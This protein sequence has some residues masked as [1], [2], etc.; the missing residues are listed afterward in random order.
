M[1]ILLQILIIVTAFATA[2]AVVVHN[3]SEFKKIVGVLPDLSKLNPTRKTGF[4]KVVVFVP[5]SHA[6]ALRSAIA[7]TGGGIIGHYSSTSFSS[8]GIGRFR[9]EMGAHP[10]Q[11]SVGKLELVEEERIEFT[12]SRELL[13]EVVAR[14]RKMHPYE[15]TVID[16]YPLEV[17]DGRSTVHRAHI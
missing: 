14:I 17:P 2:Y 9:P 1:S 16:V 6:E 11:G 8:Q 12:C 5:D 13:P 7:E 3:R 10:A 4:V 15:Q